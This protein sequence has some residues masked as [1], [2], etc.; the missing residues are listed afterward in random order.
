MTGLSCTPSSPD[1]TS[2]SA[3]GLRPSF[4]G[5]TYVSLRLQIANFK[6]RYLNTEYMWLQSRQEV[7]RLS[8]H[9]RKGIRCVTVRH[10]TRT[11]VG[12]FPKRKGK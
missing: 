4:V 1:L 7:R 2:S 12:M 11:L 6:H 10:R 8:E 9:E 3:L 5:F